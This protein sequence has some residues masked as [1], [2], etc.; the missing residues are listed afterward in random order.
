MA[1]VFVSYARSSEA[2]ARRLTGLLAAAGHDAWSDAELPPHRA[3]AEVIE[4]RLSSADAV[5]S[6]WVRAEAEYARER[7]KLVQVSLDGSLPPIPFNQIQCAPLPGGDVARGEAAWRKV[8]ASIDQLGGATAAAPGSPPA[9]TTAGSRRLPRPRWLA[10]AAAGVIVAGVAAF[11]LFH[12]PAAAAPGR[13]AILPFEATSDMPAARTAARALTARLQDTLNSGEISTVSDEDAATL[14]GPDAAER[15]KALGVSLL[16]AGD[17]EADGNTVDIKIRLDDPIHHLTLWAGGASGEA[18]QIAALED[19]VANTGANLLACSNRALQPGGLTDP[20]LLKQYLA[21]CD[22]FANHDDA[23]GA[24]NTFELIRNLRAVIAGAPDFVPARTD[25]AKFSAYLAPTMP[26][27]A[28]AQMRAEAAQQVDAALKL[29]PKAPDAWLA[30]EMLLPPTEWAAREALLRK[31]V[32]FDPDWPHTNGFLAQLLQ[33]TGRMREAEDFGGRAAAAQLQIDWRP[34]GGVF[35]CDAGDFEP[36]TTNLRALFA[37]HPVGFAGYTLQ[38]CLE[39]AG[40]YRDALAMFPPDAANDPV[41]AAQ[42]AAYKAL[43]SGAAADREGAREAALKLASG[44]TPNVHAAVY[45]LGMLGALDDAFRLA[46]GLEAGYPRTN[47][48]TAFLF[49]PPLAPMQRDPRFMRLAARLKLAQF[50]QASG[51]WPDFCA[52]P[53]WPYDCRAEAAKAIAGG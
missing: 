12:H 37:S 15:V 8:L 19:Q 2:V 27:T 20:T 31:A 53:G 5:K 46:D 25:L 26:P 6:Q 40:R 22:L 48:T 43:A 18:S 49:T 41:Q 4:E 21:A 28:A 29:D 1:K 35:A 7:S 16:F 14:R 36:A 32:A 30:K 23:T 10:F 33:Q 38:S 3:Y 42:M 24:A 45:L 50:W 34:W 11:V 51:K 9:R 13:V 17:V 44:A 47:T 52:K 39:D